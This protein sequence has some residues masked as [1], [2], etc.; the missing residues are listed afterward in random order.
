MLLLLAFCGG[1][2]SLGLEIAASRLLAPFFGTSTYIWGALIG[3]ILLC[4]TVGYYLG[5]SAADRWPRADYL[6]RLTAAASALVLLVPLVSRPVL[7]F[8]Q[9]ALERVQVGAFLGALIA[10]ILLFAPAVILL[11]MVSPY[12][13]RLRVERVEASGRT[14]GAVYAVSTAGSI[15]GAFLPAFWWIPSYGTRAT[16]EGLGILLLAV[17]VVGLVG[18]RYLRA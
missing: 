12:V 8:S 2:V 14:A 6:Y 17:S 10:V 18:I 11:G 15:L 3:L 5:G 16:I 13:V 1:L 7:L 4:L 9:S